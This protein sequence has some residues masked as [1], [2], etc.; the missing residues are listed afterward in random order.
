MRQTYFIPDDRQNINV[1][2]S[3]VK[4]ES[5][6]EKTVIQWIN[7]IGITLIMCCAL[8]VSAADYVLLPTIGFNDTPD[9]LNLATLQ[10]S[11]GEL[12]FTQEQID[13]I[14][15]GSCLNSITE[16]AFNEGVHPIAA[17][18]GDVGTGD[19][20]ALTLID[21]CSIG[22]QGSVKIL[23]F[24]AHRS[25]DSA[26]GQGMAKIAITIGIGD[27]EVTKVVAQKVLHHIDAK[28]ADELRTGNIC[29][30]SGD[31]LTATMSVRVHTC[32]VTELFIEQ[33]ISPGVTFEYELQG[34]DFEPDEDTMI[35]RLV[36]RDDVSL[37][38]RAYAMKDGSRY[39]AEHTN[40]ATTVRGTAGWSAA[41]LSEAQSTTPTSVVLGQTLSRHDVMGYFEFD[42]TS[43]S[44]GFDAEA[45]DGLEIDLNPQLDAAYL[46]VKGLT[47][48][49]QSVA[50][51][52]KYTPRNGTKE[53][54]E[55]T[56][57][58]IVEDSRIFLTS[59][60]SLTKKWEEES[61]VDLDG[62]DGLNDVL[63]SNVDAS[64]GS[65]KLDITYTVASVP[66]GLF[67]VNTHLVSGDPVLS[68]VEGKKVPSFE[69]HEQIAITLTA[70]PDISEAGEM[71]TILVQVEDIDDPLIATGCEAALETV[72]L[73]EGESHTVDYEEI[74]SGR[75]E[76]C[77]SDE[78]DSFTGAI[79]AASNPFAHYTLDDE[80]NVAS[81]IYAEAADGA[82]VVTTAS[83]EVAGTILSRVTVT[84]TVTNNAEPPKDV[85]VGF[86]FFV[87]MLTGENTH[88][89]FPGGASQVQVS[90]FETPDRNVPVGPPAGQ[91]WRATDPNTV[92]GGDV[93]EHTLDERATGTGYCLKANATTGSIRTG[94][95]GLDFETLETNP[96]AVNL[97]AT[98]RYEGSATLEV[99]ITVQNV[100]EPPTRTVV[101][102]PSL[103]A[104]KTDDEPYLI[105][106]NTYYAPGDG[107]PLEFEA[108]SSD[109]DVVTIAYRSAGEILLHTGTI[110]GEATVTVG[111]VE[112]EN[113]TGTLPDPITFPVTNFIRS[114]NTAPEF[115]DGIASLTYEIEETA[116]DGT[117]I[118]TPLAVKN[119]ELGSNEDKYDELVYSIEGSGAF[120]VAE[121]DPG[122]L[123]VI[124]GQLDYD[125]RPM[126]EFVLRVTDRFGET[127]T[128]AVSVSVIASN[129]PPFVTEA[130]MMIPE[131]T[132]VAGGTITLG[133]REFFDDP[134]QE[135][136]DQ[137]SIT[138][139][140]WQTSILEMT[141]DEDDVAS[142]H[143][144]RLGL[145][146]VTVLAK[147]S[148]GQGVT[149]QIDVDVKG[150]SNPVLDQAIPNQVMSLGQI[151][152][153]SMDGVFNDP[154][155][156][157]G[158]A[159]SIT[160]A[161][162]S[163]A[164]V[165]IATSDSEMATVTLVARAAGIV[166]V[167]VTAEDN[168]GVGVSD[169]FV[170]T[171]VDEDDTENDDPM[172]IN[173]ISNI[174]MR[175]GNSMD[176]DTS[177]TFADP[178]GDVLTL[179]A[180]SADD[181]VA[182]VGEI[183]EDQ[184]LTITAHDNAVPEG[185]N[186]VFV[187]VTV[188][189]Q[190]PEG[191]SVSHRFYVTV[192]R[193]QSAATAVAAIGSRN[194]TRGDLIDLDMSGVF[195]G[196]GVGTDLRLSLQLSVVLEDAS[197]AE[198]TFGKNQRQLSL[199]GLSPGTTSV[200]LTAA[201]KVGVVASTTFDL[202][203]D[204]APEA[205]ASLPTIALE[206]GGEGY[207][208]NMRELFEDEDGDLLTY[209]VSVNPSGI[210]SDTVNGLNVELNPVSPGK[211]T[212]TIVAEDQ[213][214]HSVSLEG[215]IK[216]S[217][218]QIR[219]MAEHTLA[220]FGRTIFGS[221]DSAIGGRVGQGSDVSD[222]SFASIVNSYFDGDPSSGR[223]DSYAMSYLDPD[224][225]N[226]N[227]RHATS[228]TQPSISN[229]LGT[230]RNGVFAMKLNSN[231][232]VGSMSVWSASDRQ[233]FDGVSYEGRVSN[234]YVGVDVQASG[235]L[236]V[237]LAAANNEGATRFESGT[238]NQS[239]DI[240]LTTLLPYFRYSVDPV[241]TVWGMAGAG[242]GDV[243]STV[244]GASN[245][246][247]DMS[248]NLYMFGARR[249][250]S[251]LGVVDLAL[252]G[253]VAFANLETDGGDGAF[254][255]MEVEINRVRA[256]LEGSYTIDM[257]NGTF[258]PFADL[259][260]RND[261]GD[262]DTGTGIEVSGG[263]RLSFNSFNLEA[264]GRVLAS[265]GA[266]DYSE[267]GF[268]LVATLNPSADGSGISFTL[269][270]RWGRQCY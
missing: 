111:I 246:T 136:K 245:E 221:I 53:T 114:D 21:S 107:E 206:I 19:V 166:N 233:E 268:S 12:L 33:V 263:V 23:T 224:S 211:A 251:K 267:H 87:A 24:E 202:T 244:V 240:G 141:I 154:D 62:V 262:G 157:I 177:D 74:L 173:P 149:T 210:V 35:Y 174:V 127:D 228:S 257:G 59:R 250:L 128:V 110:S 214:G 243:N 124:G 227:H 255:G 178:D 241:T 179:S 139:K 40:P 108:E 222:L 205:L 115:P 259:N 98:D 212:I 223:Q 112:P 225:R 48:G 29:G 22:G 32:D 160:E 101:P 138:A 180:Q 28:S 145:A 239:M 163:D 13:S 191:E 27:D 47:V 217:D 171:V 126:E 187:L 82:A 118:G 143:G 71:M 199:H 3:A 190:D 61:E 77:V 192:I 80:G 4:P 55:L 1:V 36:S 184:L 266:D 69:D 207:Q 84:V 220:G 54:V 116:V 123:K 73:R 43:G 51:T 42:R 95:C 232:G 247:S 197:I 270:P 147:D 8:P 135:D 7:G 219:A 148:E 249:G 15:P 132:V 161:V 201:D 50:I 109:T 57:H 100:V 151:S 264:R 155:I 119:G 226:M 185:E 92:N 248:L 165:V 38:V 121:D 91:S 182:S 17:G 144:L 122:Q 254:E 181:S 153:L 152:D 200:T 65:S 94:S 72:Y 261:G 11:D 183:G 39:S 168:S 45:T 142:M 58:Y 208:L 130:G 218:G 34:T 37:E 88:P 169:S 193:N 120:R 175:E 186:H 76:A 10:D 235:S 129:E 238:F 234:T 68:W 156:D 134:D 176:V 83:N 194:V 90:V 70:K 133:L 78:D 25:T 86:N 41:G 140:V 195:F 6:I 79:T 172:V 102:V 99:L 203:V 52:A 265:Q 67:E 30:V 125:T 236:R 89:R 26:D 204:T 150:N 198:A 44:I 230:S 209:A 105:D 5:I 158:D 104:L 2:K 258:V 162:A 75:I 64:V 170:V 137:L 253:D 164:D 215:S 117:S 242:S 96:I 196:A 146:N 60:L 213:A 97:I 81:G 93:V 14:Q 216:V 189:A 18:F 9:S 103:I 66:E 229:V 231:E 260:V 56:R 85:A 106:M 20:A 256:G 46:T 269:A 131:Q 237:G 252:R 31:P 63:A 16:H 159:V 113:S 188:T 167:T 49:E